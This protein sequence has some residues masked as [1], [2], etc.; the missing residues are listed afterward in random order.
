MALV[1][2]LPF[3]I[4]AFFVIMAN[5]LFR[6]LG[7]LVLVEAKSL[8]RFFVI[9]YVV[10]L[11]Y[12]GINYTRNTFGNGGEAAKPEETVVVQEAIEEVTTAPLV[13][14]ATVK[15]EAIEIATE[16]IAEVPD[17]ESESFQSSDYYDGEHL[18]TVLFQN[19]GQT[20]ETFG[21][22]Y[23]GQYYEGAYFVSYNADDRNIPVSFS[24]AYNASGLTN[25]LEPIELYINGGNVDIFGVMPGMKSYEIQEIL[26]DP[27]NTIHDEMDDVYYVSY[28]VDTFILEF[29]FPEGG[30]TSS[31]YC[32]IK[33]IKG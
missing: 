31:E 14:E 7:I 29:A 3:F 33:R 4:A 25:Q 10:C 2:I 5:L 18:L 20:I 23:D 32:S 16:V 8:L 6:R 24:I 27:M 11:I 30:P 1:F 21:D 22:N 9:V 15:T 17:Q 13:T 19:Y 26:G 12:F 28:L